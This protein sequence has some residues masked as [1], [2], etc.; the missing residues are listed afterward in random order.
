MAK[1]NKTLDE[2]TAALW[3]Q[4]TGKEDED[5]KTNDTD[6]VTEQVTDNKNKENIN[7]KSPKKDQQPVLI[8]NKESLTERFELKMTPLQMKK[9]EEIADKYNKHKSEVM[10]RAFEY[11][12]ESLKE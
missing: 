5:N 2:K 9:L 10:R 11:F 12:V 6:S 4:N 8:N 1:K 3:L 7:D